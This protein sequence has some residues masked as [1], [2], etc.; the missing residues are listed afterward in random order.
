MMKVFLMWLNLYTIHF[1]GRYFW[2]LRIYLNLCMTKIRLMR[3]AHP[4]LGIMTL[5][6]CQTF[7]MHF[8]MKTL[9]KRSNL[10]PKSDIIHQN[11]IGS[12][13][14][15]GIISKVTISYSIPTSTFRFS[16]LFFFK[17]QTRTQNNYQ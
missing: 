6:L 17:I 9:T 14:S 7:S 4:K 5:P 8:Q 3:T 16:R 12:Y 10:F 2:L 13:K 11:H 1:M 15:H